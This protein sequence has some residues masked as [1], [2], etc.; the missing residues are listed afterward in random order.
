MMKQRIE[1]IKKYLSIN[2]NNSAEQ[3]FHTFEQIKI[4][5]SWR[6]QFIPNHFNKYT[7]S[8]GSSSALLYT[9]PWI[10]LVN[11]N[12]NGKLSSFIY[13]TTP[14]VQ[15]YIKIPIDETLTLFAKKQQNG[16]YSV[17]IGVPFWA[18]KLIKK[19]AKV[20]QY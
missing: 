3:L 7:N 19:Y 12:I 15:K 4:N 20:R 8:W 17:Y 6:E 11:V 10:D 9:F 13:N 18:N 2:I 1:N 16:I 5:P 14:Y